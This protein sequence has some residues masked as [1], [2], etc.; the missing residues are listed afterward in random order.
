MSGPLDGV[1]IVEVAAIGPAPFATML[2][3]DLGADVVRVDRVTAVQGRT[4]A[5]VSMRGLS[6]NRRSVAVDL[7]HPHG[8]EVLLRLVDRADVLIEGFRPG[9][10]ERLGFGPEVCLGR[11]P[12]LIFGRMTGWGQEGPLASRAGHDLTYAALAGALHPIGRAGEPPPPP[13]NFVA[14]FGGGGAYL[15]V[16]V[17]AALVERQRSGRGQV[18]DAAMVD[19]VASLTAFFHGLLQMGAWTTQRAS[20]L[21]D[22]AAPFYDTYAT[23]DGRFVAVG[24]LE[25]QFFAELLER[26]G[27]DPAD[28]PQHDRA[29]WPEQKER[30]AAIFAS[31]TRDDWEQVFA[32]S[33]ACVVPVLALDEAPHHPHLVARGSFTAVG[34]AT[35]PA[36]APRL[37]RT[38]AAIERDAPAF[39][40]HTVAVLAEAGYPQ[41]EIDDLLG[42]GVVASTTT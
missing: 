8:V 10:A 4:A 2:L 22:G 28:W 36:P 12:A 35:Q 13:L 18:V 1:R 27:L 24:A 33:D 21:L 5:E 30:L 19:G 16:G 34:G 39:G 37:S 31:R 29:R 20:N 9:V 32:D 7:K 11:N 6:R 38:P 26:L 14:D 42:A 25:P 3:A 17:L 23:A 40:E 15:A 41:A